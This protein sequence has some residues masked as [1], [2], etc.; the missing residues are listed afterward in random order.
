MFWRCYLSNSFLQI[1]RLFSIDIFP[2]RLILSLSRFGRP[3]ACFGIMLFVQWYFLLF[4]PK[5]S[6]KNSGSNRCILI[7]S[8]IL[9]TQKLYM[10]AK[11][12]NTSI[13]KICS[14]LLI[15]PYP[16][17]LLTKCSF[18]CCD[19]WLVLLFLW[20][21]LSSSFVSEVHIVHTQQQFTYINIAF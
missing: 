1:K 17:F 13:F 4:I 5:T 14:S 18:F 21:L 15:I 9:I 16:M 20:L 6:K 7:K 3:A 10:T 19:C 11:L 12:F 2:V 8:K